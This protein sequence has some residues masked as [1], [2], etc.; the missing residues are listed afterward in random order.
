MPRVG[1]SVPGVFCAADWVAQGP[2]DAA[3]GA[4]GLSQEKALAAG[5]EAGNLV[6][7]LSFL[8]RFVLASMI[9]ASQPALRIPCV[10]LHVVQQ[11]GVGWCRALL[12]SAVLAALGPCSAPPLCLQSWIP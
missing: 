9:S 8:E 1:T 4:K 6:R 5:L 12:A 11:A 10:L 7:A 2:G 3:G